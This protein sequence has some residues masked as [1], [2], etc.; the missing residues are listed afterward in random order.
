MK[1]SSSVASVEHE[2]RH[3]PRYPVKCL[4]RHFSHEEFLFEFSST[5]RKG[6]RS[7]LRGGAPW[8]T[9]FDYEVD[10]QQ[11]SRDPFYDDYSRTGVV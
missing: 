4:P 9:Q 8:D 2:R 5:P 11:R 10:E 6:R 1:V 3:F 7:I